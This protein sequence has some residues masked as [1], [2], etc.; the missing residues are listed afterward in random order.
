MIPGGL[1]I[2]AGFWRYIFYFIGGILFFSWFVTSSQ[3]KSLLSSILE[4]TAIGIGLDVPTGSSTYSD[5]TK[6]IETETDGVYTGKPHD[7]DYSPTNGRKPYETYSETSDYKPE[8][9]E[10]NS[11]DSSKPKTNLIL[12]SIISLFIALF[13][14][15]NALLPPSVPSENVFIGILI[16]LFLI[17]TVLTAIWIAARNIITWQAAKSKERLE[18]VALFEESLLRSVINDIETQLKEKA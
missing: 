4:L 8:T 17:G 2:N 12:F 15:I 10:S 11:S 18:R 14:I 3:G 7:R 5:T 13:F 16:I 6:T 1:E 9:P